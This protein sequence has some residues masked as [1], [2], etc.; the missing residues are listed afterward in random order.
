MGMGQQYPSSSSSSS[1]SQLFFLLPMNIYTIR[2]RTFYFFSNNAEVWYSWENL[3]GRQGAVPAPQSFEIDPPTR[4]GDKKNYGGRQKE[5]VRL[6]FDK[7][8]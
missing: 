1:H 2:I 7:A 4:W 5:M 8:N 6:L 3:I